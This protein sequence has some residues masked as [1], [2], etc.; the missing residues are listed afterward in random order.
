MLSSSRLHVLANV[1]EHGSI[2]GAAEALGLS[3]SAVSHQLS[4]FEK[5]L[6]VA[7]VERGPQRLRL[8]NAGRRMAGYAQTISDLMRSA[9]ED[10]VAHARGQAGRIRVGFINSCGLHLVP[11][12]LSTFLSQ[13]P[14]V[15]LRL[16]SGE[17][18]ELVG[19]LVSDQLDVA[20]LFDH[21]Q[22]PYPFP[23]GLTLTPLL[24]DPQYL[25]LPSGHARAGRDSVPLVDLAQESWIATNG[26]PPTPS[27][28]ERLCAAAGFIPDIRCRTDRYDVA[29]GLIRAGLGIG[30]IPALALPYPRDRGLALSRLAGQSVVRRIRVATRVGD[31]NPLVRLCVDGLREVAAALQPEL[32]RRFSERL[33]S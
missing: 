19:P 26:M 31:T 18:H 22:V 33:T 4:R 16:L 3:P 27:I 17:T 6:G 29:L 21:A 23:A 12:A 10:V 9:E 2:A 8:T 13:R 32:D 15:E 1:A 5:E 24:D 11:L 7:L 28:H 14:D 25:V 30:L 20:V